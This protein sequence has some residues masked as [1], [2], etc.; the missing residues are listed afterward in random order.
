MLNNIDTLQRL[1]GPRG[2]RFDDTRALPID[3]PRRLEQAQRTLGRHLRTLPPADLLS[4]RTAAYRAHVQSTVRET[5]A[6]RRRLVDGSYGTCTDCGDQISLA[7]LTERPWTPLCVDCAL[8][9]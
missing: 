5:A 3:A 2:S 4:P 1:T 9:I 7:T 6:A 8:D